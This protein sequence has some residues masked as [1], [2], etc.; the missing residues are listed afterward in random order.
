MRQAFAIVVAAALTGVGAVGAE[1]WPEF[2]GPTGQGRAQGPLPT[3]WGPNRN[4][5]WKEPIPG[6]GWSSPIVWRG[7]VYL[8]TAVTVGKDLSLHVLS[9][10]ATTGKVLWDTEA[11]R[12]PSAKVPRVH[13]KNSNASPTPLVDD[14]RLYAHFGHLGTVCLDLDGMVLWRNTELTYQSVH[15]NGGSPILVDDLLVF[16]MDGADRQQVIALARTTGK[17]RWQTDRKC[18]AF[19]KFSFGTPLLIE[20]QGRRQ[21]VSPASDFVAAYD[22]KT[23][24]ELW[25]VHYEGYSLIPRPVFGHGLVFLSTGYDYPRLL[26]IRPDGRGDV[27][28]THVVWSRKKAVPLTP[29]PLLAGAELY[30]VSD[31]GVASCLDAKTGQPHWTERLGGD[32]SASPLLAGGK[33]YFQNE[34]GVGYVVKAETRFELV[35][36]NDMKE[37]TLASYA[38]ADGAIFLRTA[39]HL[40]RIEERRP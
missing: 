9:L 25:R 32:F 19:K 7:R 36:R 2:R 38:A 30:V 29:S 24:E 18:K 40:Y 11:I 27:T 4:V 20:F 6:R 39:E 31:G 1:D 5:V 23:G 21:I 17:V 35:A 16:N 15:G 12:R 37:R 26:A 33:V 8:S 34:E 28:D 13:G 3:E 10:D 22:P 14:K